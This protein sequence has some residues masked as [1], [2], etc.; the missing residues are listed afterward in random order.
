MP[1]DITT[2]ATP[3]LGARHPAV[4]A[5][6]RFSIVL[7]ALAV[8][9]IVGLV[10]DDRTITGAPAWGK[11]TKF[12]LSIAIYVLSLSWLLSLLPQ[13]RDRLARIVSTT[14]ITFLSIEIVAIVGSAAFGTT[15][16]FNVSSPVHT[17]IWATMA[18]AIS[19]VWIACFAVAIVLMR[20]QID[21]PARRAAIRAAVWISL[22]GMAVAFLMTGPTGA[23]LADPQGIA[24]A[25]TVGATDGGPGLPVLGWSTVA[26]DIR[27]PHFVGMHAL[28]AIPIFA[29]LLELSATK[30]ALLRDPLLRRSLVWTASVA[31][32]AVLAVLTAQAL[33]GEP[34]TNP[35]TTTLVASVTIALAALLT[36]ATAVI[37]AHNGTP[38]T[39]NFRSQP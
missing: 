37:R 7:G 31:Y 17:A 23:Q 20:T 14:T 13:H 15:S 1:L 12:A 30:V 22:V 24:G 27:V 10:V 36:A 3:A 38:A 28:Q 16:H 11:P 9:T 19:L 34:V 33:G 32:L 4:H 5:L 39:T 8:V 26:G 21:D 6:R 35:G 25:H 18:V 29:W 2:P